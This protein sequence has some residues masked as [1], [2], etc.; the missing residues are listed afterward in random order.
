MAGMENVTIDSLAVEEL[1]HAIDM[2]WKS[3]MA[4]FIFLMQVGFGMLEAGTVQ[5]KNIKNILIK[6]ILDVC[7]TGLSF[8]LVGYA[9]AFGCSADEPNHDTCPKYF[10]DNDFM[11]EARDDDSLVDWFFQFTF[12]STSV[13]IVSGCVCERMELLAYLLVSLS[14]S[15]F[16]YPFVAHSVWGFGFLSS[17]PVIDFA[18]SG[19]VHLTGG[20]A[21]LIGALFVGP[22]TGR[23]EGPRGK[24]VRVVMF[25]SYSSLFSSLG[26]IMLWVGWYGFNCGSV[27]SFF[28]EKNAVENV[29]VN[30]TVSAVAAVITTA[31]IVQVRRSKLELNE[32]LNASL[33]GLVSITAGANTITPKFAF[34][35]GCVSS[36][37]YLA[38]SKLLHMLHID[39]PLNAAPVHLFNGLWGIVSVGLFAEE[40]LVH[41]HYDGQTEFGLFVGGGVTLLGWQMVFISM[42]IVWT[43]CTISPV[44]FLLK[45]LNRLRVPESIE[46]SGLDV[47][48]HGGSDENSAMMD[49]LRVIQG[50]IGSDNM[51][52]E[53]LVRRL[54]SLASA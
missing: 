42:I 43:T 29:A 41:R 52:A 49:V 27:K 26:T 9:L 8:W 46:L 16:V 40:D 47:A 10:G 36:V 28:A 31:L 17:T 6:N 25:T 44:L 11:L 14:I 2:Q 39:D 37:M 13:T 54:V 48:F 21:G 4:V 15:T 32:I 3:S 12:I 33:S 45:R 19:V 34:V 1:Q 5:R 30:T 53:A 35:T 22:R 23:F 38:S 18:G 20:V 51:E 7:I 24:A 50:E